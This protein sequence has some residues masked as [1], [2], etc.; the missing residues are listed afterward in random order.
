MQDITL[1]NNGI[2][3]GD[4][5]AG[6]TMLNQTIHKLLWS[7]NFDYRHQHVSAAG[8]KGS[9]YGM[10]CDATYLEPW[11]VGNHSAV[12]L[13]DLDDQTAD[14]NPGPDWGDPA[15]AEF[16]NGLLMASDCLYGPVFVS[17]GTG[18]DY[19]VDDLEQ[20]AFRLIWHERGLDYAGKPY[21]PT[22][23]QEQRA[24]LAGGSL[25]LPIGQS[26]RTWPITAD[27]ATENEGPTAFL[28]YGKLGAAVNEGNIKL[29]GWDIGWMDS[30][31]I[32]Q[33]M[34]GGAVDQEVGRAIG[35]KWV[36]HKANQDPPAT[37]MSAEDIAL[38]QTSKDT[39]LKAAALAWW[40]FHGQFP[41]NV[42]SADLAKWGISDM[43]TSKPAAYNQPFNVPDAPRPPGYISVRPLKQGG[44][45]VRW[46]R[47]PEST[48]NFDTKVADFKGYRVW[49]QEAS[50]VNPWV[51]VKEGS[52]SDFYGV[53]AFSDGTYDL[54]AG[55]I[56]HDWN[57][58]PGVD[59]WYA[60]TAYDD[61]TQNWARPGKALESARW[62]T[63]TGYYPVGIKAGTPTSVNVNRPV[64]FALSQNAPNPFNPTTTIRFSVPQTEPV[65][66]VIYDVNG[67][68]VRTLVDGT[69]EVG[70]H[71]VSWDGTDMVGR[72]VASGVYVYRLTSAQG[73]ITKRMTLVK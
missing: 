23:P 56:Y 9:Q 21:S 36:Q 40:N 15:E 28:G 6:P 44:I 29:Q 54:P 22:T 18:A 58:T 48:P 71:E 63:W 11:G 5:T 64:G 35:L 47:E 16:F 33:M 70:R 61:G 30:I 3:Y 68:V 50:R 53:G 25:S 32:V 57:V 10:D 67:R 42:T 27:I 52:A 7:Q 1:T 38:V 49:R 14:G 2:S 34:A 66:L 13:T 73:E 60:V 31:R 26:Y 45:E 17:K 12:W 62:W 8:L 46:T 55:L 69:L 24:Y 43:A 72:S 41:A 39:A 20:P 37:W 65:K 19:N 59:Y 4:T 51:M